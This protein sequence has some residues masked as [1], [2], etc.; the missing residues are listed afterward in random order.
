MTWS[1]EEF[2]H[3]V[4]DC[5]DF[6]NRLICVD[7]SAYHVGDWKRTTLV[8]CSRL[9]GVLFVEFILAAPKLWI[10][11]ENLVSAH[12]PTNSP[13]RGHMLQSSNQTSGIKC[14][15]QLLR[16]SA[17]SHLCFAFIYLLACSCLISCV[18]L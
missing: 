10:K 18:D 6:L 8:E 1:S 13:Q 12:S 2:E 4:G 16:W 5:V 11:L 15:S 3:R 7:F 14:V 17:I 9:V